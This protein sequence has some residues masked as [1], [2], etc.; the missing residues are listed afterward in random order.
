MNQIASRNS[1]QLTSVTTTQHTFAQVHFSPLCHS[2][3]LCV[4][5]RCLQSSSGALFQWMLLEV[6]CTS[7]MRCLEISISE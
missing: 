6:T 4:V 1:P 2:L 7:H 3:F 5:S